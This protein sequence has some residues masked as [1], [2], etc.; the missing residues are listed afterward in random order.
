MQYSS[1]PYAADAAGFPA[2]LAV[3][4]SLVIGLETLPLRGVAGAALVRLWVMDRRGGRARLLGD[5]IAD[6]I[7]PKARRQ[8]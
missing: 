2:A 1:A 8:R 6:I 4:A 3:T 5:G 7:D